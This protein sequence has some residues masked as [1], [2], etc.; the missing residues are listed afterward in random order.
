MGCPDKRAGLLQGV[1]CNTLRR[2]NIVNYL[3]FFIV[4][5]SVAKL[6]YSFIQVCKL[7]IF[8]ELEL[9]SV[10]IC[11]QNRCFKIWLQE[12]FGNCTSDP[13]QINKTQEHGKLQIGLLG[14]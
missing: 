11:A 9:E 10:G 3:V 5:C 6:Y 12:T 13:N 1:S 4:Y 14:T 2:L 7:S 8:M